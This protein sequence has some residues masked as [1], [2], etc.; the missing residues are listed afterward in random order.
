MIRKMF[1]TLA[2]LALFALWVGAQAIQPAPNAVI[3][4][5]AN[6]SWPPPVYVLSGEIELLGSAN[7]T[8]MVG[9]FIEFR[10]LPVDEN[11]EAID[12]WYP[13]TL[14]YEHPVVNSVLGT[15]NTAA[16]A[17]GLYELRLTITFDTQA[18]VYFV[19]RPLRVQND[20]PLGSDCSGAATTAIPSPVGRPTL[21][22]TPTGLSTT[23]MVT[24]NLDANVRSGD[25]T[26]YPRVGALLGGE[27][28]RVLGRSSRGNGWYYIE[29]PDG[30]RGWIAPSTVT[31]SGDFSNVPFMNPPATST[32]VA[33]ATFTPPPTQ[34]NLTGSSPALVPSPPVCQQ[35]FQV[36]VNIT[37]NGTGNTT[38]AATV[39]IQDVRTSTGEVQKQ[40]WGAV[41]VLAPGANYV[42]TSDFHVSTYYNEQHTIRV[43][44]DPEG[45]VPELNESD[46][47]LASTYVL[48]QGACP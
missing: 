46:N 26:N 41:P 33:T 8:D 30:M 23:P 22:P 10:P 24:A 13:A 29:L 20:P 14:F 2:I 44:I 40:S 18:P 25:A 7:L 11:A 9:Y 31:P 21:L 45:F 35:N 48:Q 36:R 34:G 39:L 42:V 37:N 4:P 5:N 12:P 27:S 15:W 32:P 17:D 19:V 3:D 28:A 47:V 1:L 6:I 38:S 43:T 16:A